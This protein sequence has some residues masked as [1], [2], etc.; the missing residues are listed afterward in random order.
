MFVY[1]KEAL[2]MIH[3][4]KILRLYIYG[5][6]IK[7]IT[8]HQPLVWFKTAELNTRV[9]K[10][11]FKLSEFDYEVIYKPG[12]LNLN[13]DA[14]SRNP[15]E[16]IPIQPCN[17]VTRNQKKIQDKCK[18][19]ESRKIAKKHIPNDAEGV[20]S[21]ST[22]PKAKAALPPDKISSKSVSSKTEDDMEDIVKMTESNFEE[23]ALI[24]H[25]EYLKVS[26]TSS[27]NSSNSNHETREFDPNLKC[28][29][30]ETKEMI[31]FRKD[32]ILYSVTS[33]GTPCDKGARN[34]IE[35]NKIETNQ[36]LKEITAIHTQKGSKINHFALCIR[37]NEQE[38]ISTIRENIYIVL[39]QLRDLIHRLD[40]K[41]LSIAHSDNIENLPWSEI[42]LA[43]KNIFKDVDIKII[44]CNGTLQFVPIERRS[45]VFKEL[46]SSLI[47]G[48]RGV[49]KTNNRIKQNY[50]LENLREGIQ[51]R[52]QQCLNCQLKKL[53]RLKTKHPTVITDTPGT[54]FD[55]IVLDVVGPLPKTKNGYEYIL[56]MQD[57]F[58]KSC[59]AFPLKDTLATNH[60]RCLWKEIYL[61]IRSSKGR[62]H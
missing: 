1:E 21:Y 2:A 26:S 24:Q 35:F 37:G 53:V 10:W 25:K 39:K 55:K 49:S 54:V 28:Q 43:F 52:I 15:T 57:H 59:L 50:Y 8:G 31:Q 12:K 33:T 19:P 18:N 60:S 16:Q 45:E 3:A 56:I 61:F 7:I 58:S 9:Q 17:V 47:G 34:L 32:N 4:V 62:A 13:A 5:K 44:I 29:I 27:Y 36:T 48:H 38:S 22:N 40:L 46:H 20:S 42:I 30:I 11:R 51:R 41:I 6:K 23:Q 14:L